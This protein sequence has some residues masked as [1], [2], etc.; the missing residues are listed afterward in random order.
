MTGNILSTPHTDTKKLPFTTSMSDNIQ[1][2]DEVPMGKFLLSP[3]GLRALRNYINFTQLRIYCKKKSHNRTFH[4]LTKKNELGVS[5]VQYMSGLSDKLPPSCHSYT[6]FVYRVFLSTYAFFILRMVKF[7]PRLSA[8][9]FLYKQ[10]VYK[11]LILRR[12]KI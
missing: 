2:L 12:L 5:V 1:K 8:L 9:F 10:P 3:T 11:K 7:T 6:R 4:I